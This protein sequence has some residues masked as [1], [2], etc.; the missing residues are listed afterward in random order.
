MMNM[1]DPH[2]HFMD[3]SISDI[4]REKANYLMKRGIALSQATD[5]EPF[6]LFSGKEEFCTG[7]SLHRG[8]YHPSPIYDIVVGNTKR[9]R[10]LKL[11]TNAKDY[12][13]RYIYGMD[14]TLKSVET[15]FHNRKAFTEYL[16]HETNKRV[17]I[18]LDCF[19]NLSAVS[20]ELYA[21]N[22]LVCFSIVNCIF[23]GREYSYYNYHAENY[24]Y[25]SIGII[26][27]DFLNYS[28]QG[29]QLISEHYS[30]ERVDGYL[31]AYTNTTSHIR[32]SINI[33]RKA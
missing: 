32:Y 30:F 14:N 3:A 2:E 24:Y 27:C 17:G 7:S 16:L 28:P 21:N 15:I 22:Q 10:L 20:E 4:C 5:F 1:N 31:S 13:H 26:A 6:G 33:K 23:D 11:H 29:E 25:D 12:S 19:G 8:Y 9:G 18:T